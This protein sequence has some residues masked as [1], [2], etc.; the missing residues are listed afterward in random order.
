M[1]SLPRAAAEKAC[2]LIADISGYTEY[3]VGVELDHA[4]DVLADLLTV[5]VGSLDPFFRLAK[6]E[7]DAALMWTP[8]VELD[9]ST[10]LDRVE[11]CYFGFRRRLLSIRQATTC[12][13]NA[14]VLIPNLNLKM[15]VHHGDVI[16][17]RVAGYE[18]LVGQDVIIVHR[19]LKN[20]VTENLGAAAYAFLTDSCL[21]A[22]TLDP[23]KLGM[24]R[25]HESYDVVGEVAGW[26]HDLEQAWTTEQE[27]TQVYVSAEEGFWSITGELDA[28]AH[29]VWEYVTAPQHRSRWLVGVTAVNQNAPSSRRGVGT[30]NHCMHGEEATIEEILDWRPPN[31]VTVLTRPPGLPSVLMTHEVI[32]TEHG[33]RWESRI[34]LRRPEDRALLEPAL[35]VLGQNL[36]ASLEVLRALLA[37]EVPVDATPPG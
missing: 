27:R 11:S 9:G 20:T 35:P 24:Q 21:A 29:V 32:P 5:V 15:V 3:L 18:E 13:C 2:L 12:D 34:Q 31:Y 1:S 7:G 19:L 8:A 30:T 36:E 26:V 10:L 17:H 14:C 25:H 33:A 6:L 37:D 22:T 16:R 4:H 23:E 28:P